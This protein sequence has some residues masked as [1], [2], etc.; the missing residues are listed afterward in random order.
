MRALKM[1]STVVSYWSWQWP[2]ES[3]HQSW[4]SY[5][6]MRHCQRTQLQPFCHLNKIGKVKK[7]NK[8]VP[9]ELIKHQRNH[10]F[11]VSS[12]FILWNNNEPFLDWTVT[13]DERRPAQ[14]LDRE[15]PKHF[16]K[17][18]CTKKGHSPCLVICCL[19]DPPQLS[20]TQWNQEVCSTNWWE[21]LNTVAPIASV[22]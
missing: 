3:N 20:E 21:A 15:A 10:R 13:H 1:R 19:S 22:G 16:P 11:E 2:V 18:D 6:Y 5:N 14:W 12:S 8:W 4:S 7:L 17:P 9:H